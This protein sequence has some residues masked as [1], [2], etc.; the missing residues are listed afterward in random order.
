MGLADAGAVGGHEVHQDLVSRKIELLHQLDLEPSCVTEVVV[1]PAEIGLQV[2]T[3]NHF[4]GKSGVAVGKGL[5]VL[6]GFRVFHVGVEGR[7]GAAP[8]DAGAHEED[9]D[10]L[11]LPQLL[12]GPGD[13]AVVLRDL[14]VS[15]DGPV[16]LRPSQKGRREDP[17]ARP[18]GV[19]EA[20]FQAH[21]VVVFGEGL[22]A[23]GEVAGDDEVLDLEFDV[24]SD[25][26]R[27]DGFRSGDHQLPAGHLAEG[28]LVTELE[29]LAGR[30][31]AVG[32]LDLEGFK[33]PLDGAGGAL[34]APEGQAHGVAVQQIR[35]GQGEELMEA[36]SGEQLHAAGDREGRQVFRVDMGVA[37]D[38]QGFGRV[39]VPEGDVVRNV[40]LSLAVAGGDQGMEFEGR[41]DQQIAGIDDLRLLDRS[42]GGA[43]DEGNEKE[44]SELLHRAP[45]HECK[46]KFRYIA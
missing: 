42:S 9:V 35:L 7:I 25:L 30:P 12:H 24:F 14:P 11:S 36:L 10:G 41:V 29:V 26:F 31:G 19:G 2:G 20:D 3:S 45:F 5:L 21:G 22:F 39:G 38:P 40:A 46:L 4:G 28:P 23:G 6:G 8:V 13:V 16:G 37:V 15:P 17:H 34:P 44:K 18:G 27:R 1:G 33:F 43:E 32:A